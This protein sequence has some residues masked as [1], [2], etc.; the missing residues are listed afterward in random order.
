MSRNLPIRRVSFVV[1]PQVHMLDLGGPLQLF[2]SVSELGLAPLPLRVVGPQPRLT[3]FQGLRLA[4]VEPLPVR[5]DAGELI[6]VVGCKLAKGARPTPQQQGVVD[7]LRQ[8]A[9]PRRE[10]LTIASVCTGALL[11][12]AAGLLDGRECTTHHDY[13]ATLQRLCPLARVLDK[14]LLVDDGN[15]LTSAGVAAGIDLALHLIARHFGPALAIRVARDNVVPFRRMDAD[16]ALD[17]RLQYRN[18]DSPLVHAVQD[19]LSEHSANAPAYGTLA[20]RFGVSYRHLARC[21]MQA[22]GL[23]LKAYHQ[24]LRLAMAERLLEQS[25]WPIERV[26]EHCG[27]ATP[28]AFRAAWRQRHDLAPRQWRDARG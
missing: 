28:Q 15:L 13:L 25:D 26:A 20:G 23:T 19:Y 2:A 8:V 3:S 12:G 21:F 4:D 27:F 11:L 14:R 16:P 9:A 1:P 22:C 17:T 7:W 18:H 24:Q 6:V 10:Q 5:L